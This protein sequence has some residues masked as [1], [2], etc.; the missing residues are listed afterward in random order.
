MRLLGFEPKP[1]WVRASCTLPLYYRR[2]MM[3]TDLNRIFTQ[4][5]RPVGR[6]PLDWGVLTITLSH[7]TSDNKLNT[8]GK[9]CQ[10]TTLLQ[11]L[12]RQF[13]PSITGRTPNRKMMIACMEISSAPTVKIKIF[14]RNCYILIG[15]GTMKSDRKK[16][17]EPIVSHTTSF[18]KR[19]MRESNPPLTRDRGIYS[20]R[21]TNRPNFT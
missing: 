21:Y 17:R 20:Y 6:I 4:Y 14:C 16:L 2:L 9:Y 10:V 1:C 5:R 19:S 12:S 18:T 7:Q 8:L 11:L 3:G 15:H 13:V